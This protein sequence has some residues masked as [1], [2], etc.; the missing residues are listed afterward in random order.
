MDQQKVQNKNENENTSSLWTAN[1]NMNDTYANN[2]LSNEKN[3]YFYGRLSI[4]LV[5]FFFL[6]ELSLIFIM[7]KI[8][9]QTEI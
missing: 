5:L 1:E 6:F 2:K 9:F 8:C 7:I 4:D 3:S